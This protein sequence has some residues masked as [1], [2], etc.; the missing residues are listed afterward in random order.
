MQ[1]PE[2][3]GDV[4]VP[5]DGTVSFKDVGNLARLKLSPF[6]G[7]VVGTEQGRS[8]IQMLER[9]DLL[10][11]KHATLPFIPFGYDVPDQAVL[12]VDFNLFEALLAAVLT[13][14]PAGALFE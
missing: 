11:A 1:S 13:L 5:A 3:L 9:A 4:A 12:R 8:M 10:T 14:R 7:L 6:D 2:G